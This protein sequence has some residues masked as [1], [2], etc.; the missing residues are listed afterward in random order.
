MK[1]FQGGFWTVTRVAGVPLRAHWSLLVGLVLLALNHVGPAAWACWL[2][3]VLS[4]ELAH[5]A[6]ARALGAE[7]YG[8]DLW[9]L[10]G[11]CWSD[12]SLSPV[13]RSL[14]AAAGPSINLALA[15][16]G[17]AVLMVSGT[18]LGHLHEPV[19]V[20]AGLNLG[21]GLLNLLPFRPMDGREALALPTRWVRARAAGR[22]MRGTAP[23]VRARSRSLGVIPGGKGEARPGRRWPS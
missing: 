12:A 17:I 21:V 5:L 10:G 22:S 11:V 20:F 4:H 15:A 19:S 9:A 13:E 6:A 16:I 14:V 23:R 3:I 2:V 1:E 18:S 7:V 8:I